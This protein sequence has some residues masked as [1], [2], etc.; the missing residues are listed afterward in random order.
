M[1]SYVFFIYYVL[2]LCVGAAGV[3]VAWLRWLR[4]GEAID[5]DY[6]VVALSILT[7]ITFMT[8]SSN[9]PADGFA[10]WYMVLNL[11]SLLALSVTTVFEAFLL[12][13]L[14][15]N[16]TR[17]HTAAVRGFAAVVGA[18]AVAILA[19]R[20]TSLGRLPGYILFALF[21]A[22]TLVLIITS[23][24]LARG[25]HGDGS[26]TTSVLF[27]RRHLRFLAAAVLLFI[28]PI[29][30]FDMLALPLG[31]F[32]PGQLPKFTP[33]MFLVWTLVF[34][35]AE[36]GDRSGQHAS[37][38]GTAGSGAMMS[39][40]AER[41]GAVWER[42]GLSDREREVASLL[43]S[44]LSYKG[45]AARLF[46]SHGT[47]KTHVLSIYRKTGTR[48]KMQL[49]ALSRGENSGPGHGGAESAG[50]TD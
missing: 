1:E 14:S 30:L 12:V 46:V 18:N 11:A 36:L 39:R 29:V 25:H 27:W 28:P 8:I 16:N 26:H 31:S 37:S 13:R 7:T 2:S 24:A 23:F 49:L 34:M 4:E 9:L 44:G 15:G 6:V 33:L 47:V 45:I 38:V 10:T 42:Y 21:S 22:V 32:G 41:A 48:T 50:L 35:A 40:D 17:I 5:R 19:L 43:T 20:P 3:A